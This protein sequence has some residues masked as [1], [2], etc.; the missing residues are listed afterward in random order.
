MY[1]SFSPGSVLP[2][3]TVRKQDCL[4]IIKDKRLYPG[5]A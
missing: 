1:A 5:R 4:E 3:A 2:D